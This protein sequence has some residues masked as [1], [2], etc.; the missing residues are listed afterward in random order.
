MLTKSDFLL[1]LKAPLH[2]WAEKHNKLNKLVPSVYEQHLM[3]QGYE[4]EKLAHELLPHATWQEAYVSDEFEIRRDA[5]I[6]NIDGTYDLYEVKSST[7]IKPEHKY[8]VT[9]QSIVMKDTTKLNKIFIVTLNKDYIFKEK[10]DVKQLFSI[11][12]VTEEVK[13]LTSDVEEKMREAVSIIEKDKPDYIENC[14]NPKTCPCID[15]CYPNLPKKSIFNI[16]YLSPKKK[17]ELVDSNIIDINDLP[18]EFKLNP[19]QRRIADVIKHNK[20]YLNKTGLQT[21]LNAFVY[22]I[23]F[24]DY[25]T[26]PLAIPIYDNYKTYQHMVFQ[27]SLHVVNEDQTITHKE[28]LETELG[29][30]SKNLIM[31]L[32]EDIGLIGSIISWNKEFEMGRNK[33]MAI[34]YPEH[35]EFL[36]DINSRMIDLA[37]FI[38]KELYIHPDFLGS[39]SIKNVLPVMVPD[40]SY[41]KLKVNKGD[42]AMLTWWEMI[43][44]N[45]KKEARALLEYC[46]LDTLAMVKIWEKLI[47]LI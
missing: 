37:D 11:T 21:F 24:L 35:K 12:D 9:F 7:T 6:K 28:Y 16:T 25:E 10:L 4:V 39:W 26:Y 38:D 14:L 32:K 43:N 45:D 23:Y 44:S 30:P 13:E 29:D 33:D 1:Y 47:K 2:L 41:K 34:L 5:S 3:K 31:K 15:T 42:Q 22:P 19:K 20:P 46:S 8:D 17:R 18:N 27:Y 40:L 36:E